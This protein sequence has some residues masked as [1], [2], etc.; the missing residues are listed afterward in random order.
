MGKHNILGKNGELA[1]A[2]FLRKKDY[3]ILHTNWRKDHLELD[4][5]ALKDGILV[6]VEVKTRKST[7][8]GFPYEA[9]N[10]SKI[11]RIVIATDSYIKFFKLDLPVRFDIIS[12]TGE[13][14]GFRIE[15]IPDAFV[16]PVW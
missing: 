5:V 16:P 9:V 4:I 8:F 6:V 3:Q 14:E 10:K 15:H 13:K 7:E 1:A 11:R 12:M 2:E